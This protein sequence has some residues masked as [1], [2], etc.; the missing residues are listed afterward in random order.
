MTFMMS[1]NGEAWTVPA[2]NW[3]GGQNLQVTNT[4][5]GPPTFATANS[6]PGNFDLE[7]ATPRTA[8][9]MRSVSSFEM[10]KKSQIS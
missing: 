7:N 8:A 5:M 4:P 10:G 9:A 3:V 1:S 2:F 6:S